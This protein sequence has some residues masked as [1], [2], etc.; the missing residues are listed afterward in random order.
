MFLF[1]VRKG[2]SMGDDEVTT[3]ADAARAHRQLTV[4]GFHSQCRAAGWI[5]CGCLGGA[6]GSG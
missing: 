1:P 2:E 5:V 4:L 3:L 6:G